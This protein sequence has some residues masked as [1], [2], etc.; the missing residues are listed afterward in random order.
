MVY[1]PDQQDSDDGGGDKQGDACDNCPM[2]PN[3]DQQ[4]LDKDGLGDACDPDIDEDGIINEK[5]NC[6]RK[7]NPDQRDSDGDG[8]G[9]VC[10]NCPRVHNPTQQDS[11]HDLVGDAC[12]INRD[13]DKYVFFALLT[14]NY[15]ASLKQRWN[16]RR[17]G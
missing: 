7:A 17:R 3:T 11:D 5:D 14:N 2:V 9:D 10:D 12:D 15:F 8:F 4:D 6:P 1:N 13:I 16:Q